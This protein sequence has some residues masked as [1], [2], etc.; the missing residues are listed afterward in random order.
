[1]LRTNTIK[2]TET[3]ASAVYLITSFFEDKEPL[4]W[5]LRFL[6]T[7]LVSEDIKDK[8]KIIRETGSLFLIAKNSGL[9]S[10]TNHNIL[11]EELSKLQDEIADSISLSSLNLKD[12]NS[13]NEPQMLQNFKAVPVKKTARQSVI[14]NLLK[15][16]K[17]VMIKDITC[18]INGC[19]EK[20]VQR[21]LS[22]MVQA[23]VLKKMGEKRWSRYSLS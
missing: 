23:G 14:L 15:D 21:E 12:K 3:L 18:L 7:D 6:L 13:N 4:K 5:K 19:S 22:T 11:V 20:T 9:V 16:K 17:E 8:F 2:K 10:E 1:M